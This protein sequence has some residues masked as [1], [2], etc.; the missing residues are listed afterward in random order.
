[1][2]KLII[3]LM[4]VI[5]GMTLANESKQKLNMDISANLEENDIKLEIN[6]PYPCGKIFCKYDEVLKF[7]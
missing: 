4:I 5:I 6:R 2:L 3:A 7:K 1:M